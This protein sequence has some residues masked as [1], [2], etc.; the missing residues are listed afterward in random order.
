MKISAA[1][2]NALRVYSG[3]P[4]ATLKFLT[5][6]LCVTLACLTPLLFLSD[7]ALKP[8]ALLTVAFWLLLLTWARVNAAAA[9]RDSLNGGSLFGFRLADPSGYGKK[10]AY[11]LKRIG[12]VLIWAVPLIASM[13]V[14][15]IHFA[16]DTD[17]FTVLRMVR[18]FGGGDLTTG[19]LYL[20]LILAFS[21][22]L[23]AAGCAFHSGDRHAF[24]REN[25]KLV[26]K[27]HGKIMLCW[28]CGLISIFPLI[29]SIVIL[30]FRYLPAMGKMMEIVSGSASLPDTKISL[31]I[32]GAGAL[33]T[34]PLLPLR[35]LITAAYVDGLEKE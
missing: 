29:V 32:L 21:L 12:L 22:I 5:V 9:M 10:V 34:I 3:H 2:R 11:G 14:A 30:V 4:G 13:V 16:G 28:L 19:I 7:G 33:L 20:V 1:F 8:L 26:G 25:P 35:S 18:Q 15:W 23:V 6:E 31:I 27:H 24:V 17:A